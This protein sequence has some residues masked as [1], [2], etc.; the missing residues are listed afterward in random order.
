[1]KLEDKVDGVEVNR[2]HPDTFQIPTDE[3]KA[4]VK[5]GDY[6][7]IGFNDHELEITEH[8]W[9]HVTGEGKG[10]LNNDPVIVDM[11]IGDE[12]TFEPRHI[13]GIIT[14]PNISPMVVITESNSV[15]YVTGTRPC[16]W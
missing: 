13:L 11:V 5:P 1:M 9:V 14:D 15:H 10:I 2:K 6:V 16:A 4:A 3:E 7:K 8:M 12:V